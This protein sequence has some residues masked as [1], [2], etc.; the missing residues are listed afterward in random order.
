MPSIAVMGQAGQAAQLDLHFYRLPVA[1]CHKRVKLE[2]GLHL[3]AGQLRAIGLLDPGE[4]RR[5]GR[6]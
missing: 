4:Q 2:Q 6:G 1:E 3:A 5:D